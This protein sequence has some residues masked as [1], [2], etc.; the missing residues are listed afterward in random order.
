MESTLS[1]NQLKYIQSLQQ[2]KF[3]KLHGVFVAEGDKIIR[4]LLQ[5]IWQI[6][7]LCA[8]EEWIS[9]H[10]SMLSHGLNCFRVSPKTLG[11]ISTLTTPNQV[12]AVVRQPEWQLGRATNPNENCLVLDKLQD[13]GNLGTIIRTADWFGISQIFCSPD[14]ADAFSPKVIQASMG[15]FMR[16]KI[17][18]TELHPLLSELRKNMPVYGAS[19]SGENLYE[20]KIETPAALL[21]GN[22]SRGISE[23]LTNLISKHLKIPAGGE[24][25]RRFRAESLNAAIATGIMLGRITSR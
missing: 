7:F 17:Y 12:L 18:Y 9:E 6:D 16:V 25:G 14:C 5:S 23:E 13:P 2:K 24:T 4:E 10:K 3:R 20:T 1:L 11:R 21:I 22:E 19:L 8:T 15:S